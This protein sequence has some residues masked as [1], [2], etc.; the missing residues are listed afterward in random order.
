MW[1]TAIFLHDNDQHNAIGLEICTTKVRD[2]VVLVRESG[3]TLVFFGDKNKLM[4]IVYIRVQS[5]VSPALT[6]MCCV[7]YPLDGGGQGV[8]FASAEYKKL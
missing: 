3:K 4:L 8:S 5:P 6:E 7:A 2:K 1:E